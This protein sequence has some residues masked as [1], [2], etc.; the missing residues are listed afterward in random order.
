[1]LG[2]AQHDPELQLAWSPMTKQGQER[3]ASARAA[4]RAQFSGGAPP[5]SSSSARGGGAHGTTISPQMQRLRQRVSSAASKTSDE[6]FFQSFGAPAQ[7]MRVEHEFARTE[8]PSIVQRALLPETAEQTTSDDSSSVSSGGDYVSEAPRRPTHVSQLAPPT[9]IRTPKRISLKRTRPSDTASVE[10][11]PLQKPRVSL[12]DTTNL[13]RQSTVSVSA[14]SW[15][16]FSTL[17]PPTTAGS[18]TSSAL[19]RPFGASTTSAGSSL[20]P[21]PSSINSIPTTTLSTRVFA[22][23]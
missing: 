13:V 5:P 19:S 6:I 23:R 7:L 18:L 21:R 15:H 4:I 22:L 1:M 17:K 2:A 8:V 10:K 16:R 11:P 3:F 12:A 14:P 20:I 9:R